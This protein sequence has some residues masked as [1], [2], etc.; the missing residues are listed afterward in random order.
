MGEHTRWD[1][2]EDGTEQT[3]P[4]TKKWEHPCIDAAVLHLS[5]PAI[6]NDYVQIVEL[7]DTEPPSGTM[8]TVSGW[9]K[10]SE[11]SLSRTL[12]KLEV[13]KASRAKCN[14]AFKGDR[15]LHQYCLGDANAH[16]YTNICSGDSGSPIVMDKG[17][18]RVWQVG[19]V[20]AAPLVGNTICPPHKRF[21]I[22][23][24]VRSIRDWVNR[25]IGE[26]L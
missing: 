8:L 21:S 9:G 12:Q 7:A 24:S 19:I 13:P 2:N 17:E 18:G 16:E 20:E 25:K 6:L 1:N 5:K 4:V 3:I 10:T 23:V 26:C 22:A 15:K 11:S 14:A